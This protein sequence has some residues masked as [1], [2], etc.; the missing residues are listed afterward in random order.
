MKY[1]KQAFIIFF[2]SFLGE[3]L[4]KFIP[5]PIPAGVYGLVML[6]ASL[7]F[8]IVKLPD[9]ENFGGFLIEAMP[10]MFVP[11]AAAVIVYYREVLA[12]LLPF[13]LVVILSTV[14]I[15]GATGLTTQFLI[16]S[17]EKWKK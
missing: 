15:I 12:I 9:V 10:I 2:I 8:G 6:L 13:V 3:L 16:R 14:V 11:G 17:K 4:N 1:V 5:L 7:C